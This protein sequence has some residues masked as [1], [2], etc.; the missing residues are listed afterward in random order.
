MIFHDAA[1]GRNQKQFNHGS[2]P[3]QGHVYTDCT[4]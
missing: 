3:T 1:F 4:D 2:L